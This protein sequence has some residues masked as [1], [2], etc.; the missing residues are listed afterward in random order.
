MPY[1]DPDFLRY[2][3]E[4]YG[5]EPYELDEDAY[6]DDGVYDEEDDEEDNDDD[7]DEDQEDNDEDYDEIE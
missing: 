1:R 2:M 5:I 3:Y 6:E 7:Y 4:K